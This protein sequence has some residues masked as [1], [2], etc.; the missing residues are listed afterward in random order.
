MT[1]GMSALFPE[2]R[3]PEIEVGE[4]DGVPTLWAPSTDGICTATLLFRV[5]RADE[6]LASAGLTHLVEHLAFAPDA[7]SAITVN[8][9][10][11]DTYTGFSARGGEADVRAFIERICAALAA[12]PV[13]RLSHEKRVIQTEQG[14][15]GWFPPWTATAMRFG[16]TGWGTLAY[17]QFGL[18]R[19]SEDDV[20]DWARRAFCKENAILFVSSAE[21]PDLTV[22]PLVSGRPMPWPVPQHI[23]GLELPAFA[24]G[25]SR[26]VV[27]S[28]ECDD[29]HA[30]GT[31]LRLVRTA[32]EQH[33]RH[34]LGLSYAIAQ[35]A[36][37]IGPGRVLGFLWAD[38]MPEQAAAVSE[39]LWSV[40][41]RVAGEGPTEEE[42]RHEL[43]KN[44]ARLDDP[45][46]AHGALGYAASSHLAGVPVEESLRRFA[47]SLTVTAAD[48]QAAARALRD[49]TLV[50][51]PCAPPA[52]FE[53]FHPYPW[54]SRAALP[55]TPLRPSGP[56][57]PGEMLVSETSVAVRLPSGAAV[58][59][60][61]CECEAVLRWRNG[62]LVFINR[63][64]DHLPMLV[65]DWRTT[66]PVVAAARAAIPPERVVNMPFDEHPR[67]ERS[68]RL[69]PAS[70]PRRAV[71]ALL[72]A[73]IVAALFVPSTLVSEGVVRAL[74]GSPGKSGHG[75]LIALVAWSVATWL[76][77]ALYE[78]SGRAATPGKQA[79][80]LVVVAES[81]T[82]LS[83]W[84]ASARFLAM[85][86]EVVVVGVGL[87]LIPFSKRRHALHDTLT[88]TEVVARGRR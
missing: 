12:P 53:S 65:R 14:S 2:V 60:P 37:A 16:A 50:V 26:H 52:A 74:G 31:T 22:A 54:F 24:R 83:F 29:H 84:R 34:G 81:G 35:F 5:G 28:M 72:D 63:R 75:P 58:N 47:E 49:S 79:K 18:Y 30:I 76:Y 55:G 32:A 1:E 25:G 59:V 71:A 39:G 4:T 6:Q 20:R 56:D 68:G 73:A 40:L 7:A 27:L 66:E 45:G 51:A 57:A 41:D 9:G 15:Q 64:A 38:C 77:F 19:V 21:R 17:E 3:P 78:S 11:S 88:H 42:L 61:F 13:D 8:G 80:S 85:C 70:I 62:D 86:G 10:V 36:T 44:R 48:V 43:R 46:V 82:T 87:V 67:Q 33:L 23:D 69:G